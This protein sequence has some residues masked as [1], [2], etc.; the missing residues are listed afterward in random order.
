MGLP[1]L[2]AIDPRFLT[3]TAEAPAPDVVF[4]DP[5]DEPPSTETLQAPLP[6]SAPALLPEHASMRLGM[7]TLDEVQVSPD[8]AMRYSRQTATP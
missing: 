5:G 1:T 6:S 2:P 7:G 3:Q 4:T 8:G